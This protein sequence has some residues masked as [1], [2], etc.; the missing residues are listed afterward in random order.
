[1]MY[2]VRF[3]ENGAPRAQIGG[4]FGVEGKFAE[5]IDSYIQSGSLFLKEGACSCGTDFVHLKIN[6]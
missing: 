5:F 2:Q 6:H 3:H 4:V 1:M